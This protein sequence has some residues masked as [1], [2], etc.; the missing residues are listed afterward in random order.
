MRAIGKTTIAVLAAAVAVLMAACSPSEPSSKYAGT[1]GVADTNGAPFDIVL[2]EDGTAS[3][4]RSGEDMKGKWKEEDGAA[5]IEW[6]DGWTTV[7]AEE[8]G[9]F[10]KKGYDKGVSRDSPPSNTSAATKKK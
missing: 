3:A 5:I 7:I 8:D 6:G 4:N 10:T 1:W 2:V 9:G